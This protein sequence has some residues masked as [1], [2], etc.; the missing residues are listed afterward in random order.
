MGM[1]KM[2]DTMN[3]DSLYH[4]A[5]RPSA[6]PK[7]GDRFFLSLTNTN[8]TMTKYADYAVRVFGIVTFLLTLM[9]SVGDLE[10]QGVKS[11]NVDIHDISGKIF[12]DDSGLYVNNKSLYKSHYRKINNMEI[13]KK[14]MIS[15]NVI[16]FRVPCSLVSFVG[17]S[18]FLALVL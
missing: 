12:I 6:L 17:G 5:G 18:M 3:V 13:R 15:R 14:N 7:V 8:G 16:V 1:K 10:P 11:K 4:C 2:C 9:F